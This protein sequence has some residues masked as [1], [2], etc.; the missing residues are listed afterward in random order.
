MRVRILRLVQLAALAGLAI[1]LALTLSSCKSATTSKAPA[2]SHGPDDGHGHDKSAQTIDWCSEHRVPESECTKCHP[3][4]AAKWKDKPGQ[5]CDEHNVPEAHCYA[6]HPNIKFPQEQQYLDQMKQNDAKPSSDELRPQQTSAPKL[7]TALFRR[8][9]PKCSTDEAVI[10]LA[11]DQAYNRVGLTIEPVQESRSAELIEAVGE[12]DFDPTAAA[13]VTSLVSGTLVRWLANVGE[14]VTRGQV[15]AYLESL[16]G[17]AMRA[18][19][20]EAAAERES[21]KAQFERQ[22][23]LLAADLTSQ[24]EFQEARAAQA[25]AEAAF[26]RT[27]AALRVIGSDSDGDGALVPI[28]AKQSCILAEQSVALGEVINAGNSIGLIADPQK[29]WVEARVRENELHRIHIGQ[30]ATM[31][32]DEGVGRTNG[33]VIWVSPAVDPATRM[34]RVRIAPVKGSP[35]YAHQFVD[36][37]IEASPTENAILVSRE[38]VQWEGCC[39]VVFVSETKDRFRPRKVQ[40]QYANGE[41]YAVTGL[42]EG[43]EIVTHGSYLL[44]TELMKEGLGAGCCGRLE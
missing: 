30:H 29:L 27:A 5:W 3:E 6:C 40:V 41:Q 32:A 22:Q 42:R 39:N 25:R 38:A 9:E 19:Y 24:K 37:T 16:E 33:E 21:A 23:K 11:T 18:E 36:V 20:T 7:A 13:A 34:G 12:V 43:E 10:Q 2:E 14:H 8:N 26:E 17:A 4:L 31:S 1:A 15:L 28:R 35:L 44:K